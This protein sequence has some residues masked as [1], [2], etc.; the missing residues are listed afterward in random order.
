MKVLLTRT[1]TRARAKVFEHNPD[2][3]VLEANGSFSS[4]E[5]W[6]KAAKLDRKQKRAFESLIAAFLLSFMEEDDDNEADDAAHVTP[7]DRTKFRA[8]QKMLRKLMGANV[9]VRRDGDQLIILIHG[10][11]GSGKSTV[12]NLVIAYAQEY[13]DHLGH[14]FTSRTIV[15]T[16]MSGVAATLLH[17][18]TTHSALALMRKIKN[19]EIEEWADTR[20]VIIDEISFASKS[21]FETACGNLQKLKKQRYRPYGG[22]NIAFLGDY[23]QL[24]P[25]NRDPIYAKDNYCSEFHGMLNCYIELD[26]KHRFKDDPD[27]GDLNFRMREGKPTLEDIRKLNEK[28][29]VGPNRKPAANAQVATC[30]NKE[31]DAV[32]ASVFNRYCKDNGTTDGTVYKGALVI[33]MDKLFMKDAGNEMTAVKSNAVKR[34]FWE[35]VGEADCKTTEKGGPNRT[36]PLL[37]LCYRCPM[38]M[39][40]NKAVPAG[41]A[42]GSRVLLEAVHIKRGEQPFMMTLDTGVKIRAFFASQV[43][44][45]VVKHESKDIR[46]RTFDMVAETVKFNCRLKI[47]QAKVLVKMNGSQFSLI[48]NSCTTGH[49]LQGYTALELFVNEWAYHSNWS[50]VVLSRV[51]TMLG[52][53]FRTPLEEDLSLY[54]MPKEMKDMLAKFR[55]EICIKDLSDDDY[56]TLLQEEVARMDRMV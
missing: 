18:E 39:T 29:V 5:D 37:K 48:S 10:P 6:A 42:N 51:R 22:L 52:L 11:G 14:P 35:T 25:V 38:M 8:M 43:K 13:C 24:V 3:Q 2:A 20:L 54:E 56:A 44:K 28:C 23:S 33:L 1:S 9:E 17:G 40:E 26:G 49:K 19:D 34:Y 32:N 12:V 46:P 21:D 45:L 36:D 7:A 47:Q 55:E 31:R 41:Q 27:F 4:I 53:F 15:V 16:A 30:F 50:H